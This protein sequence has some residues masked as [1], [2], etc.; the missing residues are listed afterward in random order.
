MYMTIVIGLND[1]N[2]R[3]ESK[4]SDNVAEKIIHSKYWDDILMISNA[5]DKVTVTLQK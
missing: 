2:Y 4:L 3:D 1:I 5:F